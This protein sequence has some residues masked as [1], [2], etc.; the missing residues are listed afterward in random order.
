[1]S[2]AILE[3]FCDGSQDFLSLPRLM[4]TFKNMDHAQNVQHLCQR[5]AV[6]S[7]RSLE[8]RT[9]NASN[10]IDPKS[11]ILIWD[12]GASFGL[13]PFR[14]D[15]IDYVE[16]DIAVKDVTKVNRVIGIGTTLHKFQNDK[17]KDVFLPCVSYHLP[18]TDVRLFSPQT[19]H[20]MHGGHSILCGDCVE[21]NLKDNRIVIPI[22]RELANLPIVYNSFVS[23]KEK[24][25][26]GPHIRSAM[27]YSNL[28]M[29]DF[30]GDLQTS[31]EMI[32]GK[33]GY[34]SIVKNEFE[35]YAQFCGPCVGTNENENLSNAQK[36]LLLWHWKWG[37][38]MH[39]IQELM[40]SQ[41]V[42]ESDGTKHIMAPIIK[43]KFPTAA[44]CAVPVCES[45]LLGR[46]KKRSPGVAKKKPVPEKEGILAR[47]KYEVGDFMSTDQFVVKTPGRL[48]SGFGRERHNNRFHGG[49]IYN[50]AA[51]GLIWVENQVSL[52][53]NETIVGKARFEQWLWEQAVAEVSH[54]HSDNGIFVAVAYRKDCE[55]KGQTQSFSGVGAQHQNSRAERSIQT[56][57]Y[58]ARTF[59]IHSSLNWTDKGVDDL[60]LWSFAVK[61]SVWVFNRVSNQKSGI[62]PMEILTKTNSNHQDL[63]RSH[64]WGCPVF[65]L[66]AKLQNDQKLPKWNRRSRMGQ[67][68]GFSDEHSTLVATV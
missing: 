47:D 8:N 32:N 19:Y 39:R 30:F 2:S 55:G 12:T 44:K 17:G 11:L 54:Y 10:K 51:S 28:S 61:H 64:V 16:A 23:T 42:E 26:V 14:S 58:M 1:M 34:E 13:T 3:S 15:F 40:R 4:S 37:I 41:R 67:F 60:T 57:M 65:V 38:S 25:D 68:L 53:A 63:R 6:L 36:E 62:S 46:A 33:N 20:Q 66:E 5:L 48:P 43:P 9:F 24:R 7:D 18:T 29:L 22:R 56:I 27:A 52:R 49:T 50:D 59:M 21:M 45:C 31:N 35:H